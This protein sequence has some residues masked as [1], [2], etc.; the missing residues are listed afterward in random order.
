M[1]SGT[2]E[3]KLRGASCCWSSSCSLSFPRRAADGVISNTACV[4][5]NAMDYSSER[6][7]PYGLCSGEK[8]LH[9]YIFMEVPSETEWN[10]ALVLVEMCSCC[11]SNT[12][13][14]LSLVLV[15]MCSCCKSN[16]KWNLSLVLVEMCSCH[17]SNTKRN[18]SLVLVEMCKSKAIPVTG[19]GGL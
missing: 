6:C 8:T 5:N 15:E 17:K 16:T 13:W 3:A 9:S 2:S 1:V 14:N 10:L 18:L 12:K 19:H 4:Q 11:K 7:S